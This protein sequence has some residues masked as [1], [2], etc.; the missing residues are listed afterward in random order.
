MSA[1]ATCQCSTIGAPEELRHCA[2]C[3]HYFYGDRQLI[4]V[5]RVTSAIMPVDYSGINPAVLENAR[6]RGQFVDEKFCQWLDTGTVT[7]D[8]GVQADW[9][10]RLER[11]VTWWERSG[12]T[13]IQTQK[14]LMDD[15][16][17][18][19]GICD[20]VVTRNGLPAILDLKN[21]S[22]V[23]PTHRLQLGAY[24][25]FDRCDAA[26]ILHVTKDN[27]RLV[28]LAAYQCREDWRTVKAAY[29]VVQRLSR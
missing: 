13:C 6:L 8:A 5:G 9:L 21:T 25:E 20:F 11:L 26:G 12:L 2:I 3:R 7:I 14:V 10:D 16:K 24:C 18:Y 28:E 29:E 22:K 27:V 4:G 23:E 17:Q 1:V 15:T 19:V